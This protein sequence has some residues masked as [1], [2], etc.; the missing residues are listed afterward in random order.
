MRFKR[1]FF[2]RSTLTVAP[3]LLGAYIVRRWRNQTLVARITELEAYLGADDLASH[4]A[5]G[6][7][8]RNQ[9]LW[10]AGGHIYVYRIYGIHDCL[11]I[12]TEPE[13]QPGAILVRELE[14]LT[15]LGKEV[16]TGPGRVCRA[17]HISL[18]DN[19]ID[20][21]LSEELYL[22]RHAKTRLDFEVKPRVGITKNSDALWR[23]RLIENSPGE[24][25][26]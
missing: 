3:D 16:I 15:K 18:A 6:K 22:K 2:T 1:S 19:G 25:M 9:S 8:E 23:F 7:T 24:G 13:G 4:A 14:L 21:T 12:V 10:L 17:L 11:N 26:P 5:K 20:V